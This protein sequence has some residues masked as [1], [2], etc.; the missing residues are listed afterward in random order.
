M[1]LLT[2]E[3]A[4]QRGNVTR[5]AKLGVLK[6]DHFAFDR[7]RVIDTVDD[8]QSTAL[9]GASGARHSVCQGPG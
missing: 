8:G 7:L 9:G 2:G 4:P 5:P 1:K 6:Q 3:L